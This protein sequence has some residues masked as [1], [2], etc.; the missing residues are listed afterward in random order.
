MATNNSSSSIGS[1]SSRLRHL[2]SNSQQNDMNVVGGRWTVATP[3]CRCEQFCVLRT[4]KTIPNYGR[5]FWGCR[6]YKGPHD[7]GCNYFDWFDKVESS[8]ND[9]GAKIEEIEQLVDEKNFK[10]KEYDINIKE[11]DMKI[12]RQ[13][14]KIKK[15]K[16]DFFTTRKMLKLV[17][18]G[19]FVLLCLIVIL[20]AMI[21]SIIAP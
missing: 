20:V 18:V 11:K 7:I 15:L 17:S 19:Y 2:S 6:N 12:A 8:K 9:V 3:N 21:W 4:A 10:M 1:R 14:K 13:R 5:K 16:E